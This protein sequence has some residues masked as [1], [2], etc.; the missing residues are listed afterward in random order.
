MAEK[1]N[2]LPEQ[3]KAIELRNRNILVSASA[4]AGKTAVLTERIISILL[5]EEKPVDID[6]IVVVTFT[7]AAASE[8]RTRVGKKLSQRLKEESGD[9]AS[10]IRKQIALLPHAQ[11]TTIDSFC[12]Y[13]LRNYF[14]M[15]ALD[16]AFKIADENDN[17][18]MMGEVCDSVLE[19]C[20]SEGS[21]RFTDMVEH[22]V[23]GKDDKILND[24]ILKLYDVSS[25]H[26]WPDEWLDSCRKAFDQCSED[27]F[28]NLDWLVK[29][30]LMEHVGYI[31]AEEIDR[32]KEACGMCS[33]DSVIRRCSGG[34]DS[35][36]DSNMAQIYEFM[37]NEAE[38]LGKLSECKTYTEY[39][40][41][42]NALNFKPFPRKRFEGEYL[43]IKDEVLALRNKVKKNINGVISAYFG[44]PL[45]VTIDELFEYHGAMNELI[46]ITQEFRRRFALKKR[47]QAIIDF[48]DVEHM[49]LAILFER[50]EDGAVNRSAAAV[51]MMNRYEYIMVDE[52]QDSNEVQETILNAI[53]RHGG[54]DNNMFM[55]G[56]VKQSIY[57]FRLAKPDIFERKRR[58]YT[59][60]ES[61]CQRIIFGRNFRSSAAILSAVNYIFSHIMNE[62]IGGVTYDSEHMFVIG[63]QQN[64][65]ACRTE[66]VD[67]DSLTE[68]E[69]CEVRPPANSE[70]GKDMPVEVIYITEPAEESGFDA[71][72][73]F[74]TGPGD[75]GLDDYGKR[76]LEA[77]A[78]ASRI[79][80]I[81]DEDSGMM[82]YDKEAG[83]R[84]HVKYGDIVIL[85]RSMSG[86][87]EEFVETLTANGIP[88]FA[89]EKSGYFSSYEIQIVLS[90]LKIIDNPKQDIPL[91]SVLKSVYAG[92]DESELAE[93]RLCGGGCMYDALLC[94][95]EKN[96]DGET[97]K[98]INAFLAMLNEFR[99]KAPYMKVYE[100]IEELIQTKDFGLHMKAM[101]AGDRRC[102]NL[103]MLT[104][105]AIAYEKS[106][107]GGIFGFLQSIDRLKKADIDFGEAERDNGGLGAVS[108]MSIHKSKGLEFPVVIAAGMGKGF[109]L[110][111]IN[112]R[113]PVHADIGP[114]PDIYDYNR[115][116]RRKT[117][118]KK[119]VGQKML[120]DS[121]GEELR[122]LY[123]A[124]TRPENK[125]IITGY[126]KD[127]ESFVRDCSV[128]GN[129][130][131]AM[132]SVKSTYLSFITPALMKHGDW[133]T[134]RSNYGLGKG[135]TDICCLFDIKI[136][137]SADIILGEGV[138]AAGMAARRNSLARLSKEMPE[139]EK[140]HNIA[141][142]LNEQKNYR[143]PFENESAFA[144]KVSVSEMKR[145][146]GMPE[147]ADAASA[148]WLSS[149]EPEYIPRFARD[150]KDVQM[151]GAGRGTMYHSL[152]Q[153]IDLDN[154]RERK[155]VKKQMQALVEKGVL[156]AGALERNVIHIDGILKF[157]K[158]DIADRMRRAEKAGSL[159]R[160]QPFVMG[161]PAVMI[162]PDSG[163]SETIIVQGI[164]D[165][166]FEEDGEIVLLDYKT[167]RLSYGDEDKLAERYNTQMGCYAMAVEKAMGK[168]VKE[169]VLYSFSLDKAV[170]ADIHSY[171]SDT[172]N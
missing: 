11:I 146:D 122:V 29:S 75:S 54:A 125:L 139:T 9:R 84:R 16:P 68:Y 147:D 162:Y 85:L 117:L 141:A 148:S 90:L 7:R 104:D 116:T 79:R 112:S 81:T 93:I 96:K 103:R 166:F 110:T 48:N 149:E 142:L 28:D 46:D 22:I 60:E 126:V 8:M 102:G 6:R 4:G 24:I 151:S 101:P 119:A 94:A 39:Y 109:N 34:R 56:D 97:A 2:Y 171:K 80:E 49:A 18:V 165:V 167:D 62:R 144:I 58:T 136:V 61:E 121:I 73:G 157:C 35:A 33:A 152:M 15:I 19:D 27:E 71:G 74:D 76:E 154:V 161:V 92:M 42:L 115:R 160:E 156:D 53:S 99:M 127:M 153:Y 124:L 108:I 50:G 159:Y 57:Q 164:I 89:E 38:E 44:K 120:R 83:C 13:I 43:D 32:I 55:V 23:T 64:G 158:S 114:A 66:E 130:Y 5:D 135:C 163:S 172:S 123:V 36:A 145:R 59:D 155:D 14:Y 69:R 131:S 129:A 77:A 86:W 72:F 107:R 52:Y 105:K 67:E 118:I 137:T 98:K 100:L 113:F 63:E 21:D 10:H 17:R 169:A 95:N 70:F 41:A 106:G 12:L 65:G 20:Y 132:T 26:P 140:T 37:V 30:G 25:S 40:N 150:E 51:E 128:N 111:D 78:I 3:K 168:P 87:A 1:M 91:V 134:V 82:F 31:C 88:A 47:E 138:R 45:H 170:S 143:Y 133:K